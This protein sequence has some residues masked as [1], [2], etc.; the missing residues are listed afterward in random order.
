MLIARIGMSDAGNET[1]GA[2]SSQTA[3]NLV[4]EPSAGQ[5]SLQRHLNSVG[6][7]PDTSATSHLVASHRAASQLTSSHLRVRL[8][9][10]I[11]LQSVALEQHLNSRPRRFKTRSTV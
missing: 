4:I 2:A 10:S 1:D 6:H 7:A 8:V 5:H 9:R 11:V 3:A